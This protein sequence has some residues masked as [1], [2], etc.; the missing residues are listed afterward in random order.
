MNA[1]RFLSK[2]IGY[3]YNPFMAGSS[4]I[5]MILWACMYVATHQ[6][7]PFSFLVTS[8]TTVLIYFLFVV[9]TLLASSELVLKD[10]KLNKLYWVVSTLTAIAFLILSIIYQDHILTFMLVV[11]FLVFI[12]KSYFE[13]QAI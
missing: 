4:A 11:T 10:L 2:L 3:K 12:K 1:D 13:I 6:S 8:L 9:T 7:H 5:L